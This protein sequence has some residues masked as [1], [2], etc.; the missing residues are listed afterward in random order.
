MR[1]NAQLSNSIKY[2]KFTQSQMYEKGS[3]KKN[4]I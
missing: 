3:F 2:I 1:S 4:F